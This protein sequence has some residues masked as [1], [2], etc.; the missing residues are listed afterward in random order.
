MTTLT[1]P[2]PPQAARGP[3]RTR[4]RIGLGVLLG[5]SL[6]GAAMAWGGTSDTSGTTTPVLL[7]AVPLADPVSVAIGTRDSLYVVN[8]TTIVHLSSTGRLLGRVGHTT[9]PI[10]TAANGDLSFADAGQV[11]TL[12]PGG[13]L[14][15][16][17][18]AGAVQTLAVGRRG[19]VYVVSAVRA[20]PPLWRV[21]RF[22]AAGR[23]LAQWLTAYGDD[24]AVGGD[25][26]VYAIGGG[27]L[28]RLDARTGR[29]LARWV[30]AGVQGTNSYDAV[31]ADAQG[32]IYV[33]VTQGAAEAP[34]A[35]ERLGSGRT[36]FQT[37]NA[38]Q[39]LVAGLAIDGHGNIYVI[40]T[41]YARPCPSN[42]GLD[43]LAATGQVT[44][45]FRQPCMD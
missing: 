44:G 33:G 22:S 7:G 21:R 15:H 1:T 34:F 40:R 16:R 45:T 25:G 18:P 35:I 8:G 14:L 5:M 37:V 3:S 2:P 28:V 39:E 32:T 29:V 20:T 26:T 17:W 4:R 30:G 23:V 43:K 6:M 38:A 27:N 42:R 12:S 9:A 41:S 36:T 13:T 11:V 31:A 10:G 24:V 19:E